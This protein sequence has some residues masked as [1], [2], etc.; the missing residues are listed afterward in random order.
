[1]QALESQGLVV[2]L[3]HPE[4]S[5]GQHEVSVSYSDALGAA[6]NQV[7]LRETIRAVRD[8]RFRYVRNYRPQEP[9]IRPL[10]YRD[11]Q[12]IMQELNRMIAAGTL[13]PNQWQLTARTKPREELYDLQEDPHELVNLAD[14][15][16]HQGI[17]KEMRRLVA[18]W[19]EDTDDK[20]Q[21]PESKAALR[22][23]KKMFP[24][25]AVDPIFEGL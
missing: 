4:L 7:W 19:I 21:Y 1:M 3:C 24:E 9:Y 17:L 2:E 13:G 6:D 8:H 20:G 16:G 25:Q 15:P 14:D 18:E 23:L 5:P 11:R 22:I 12:A 10:S